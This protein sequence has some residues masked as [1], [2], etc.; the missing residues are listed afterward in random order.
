MYI[1]ILESGEAKVYRRLTDQEIE[2]FV[3]SSSLVLKVYEEYQDL[4]VAE[5]TQ[6]GTEMLMEIN[7]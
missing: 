1:V 4:K 7:E 3:V 5:V 6:D 2:Q